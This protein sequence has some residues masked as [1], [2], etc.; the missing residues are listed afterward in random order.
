MEFHEPQYV[1]MG[2][3][4]KESPPMPAADLYAHVRSGRVLPQ[5]MVCDLSN[6]QWV[7]AG[8]LPALGTLFRDQYGPATAPAP[9]Q[10][11]AQ[12]PA[13]PPHQARQMPAYQPPPPPPPQSPSRSLSVWQIAGGV[14]L[15]IVLALFALSMIGGFVGGCLQAMQDGA[16]ASTPN[17]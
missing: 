7:R 3:N 2:V 13:Q 6:R 4:G 1:V 5:T 14:A 15:G 10:L 17:R 11:R 16:A 8:D 12:A 9:P